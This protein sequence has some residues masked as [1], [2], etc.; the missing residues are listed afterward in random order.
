NPGRLPARTLARGSTSAG[1]GARVPGRVGP[2]ASLAREGHERGNTPRER[3]VIVAEP[4]GQHAVLRSD[5]HEGERDH[6]DEGDR[7][8]GQALNRDR[9][10]DVERDD[11]EVHRMA[12]KPVWAARDEAMALEQI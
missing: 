10:A 6:V 5:P 11:P 1:R 2:E 8:K 3:A 4:G 9:R 7:Q 12:R